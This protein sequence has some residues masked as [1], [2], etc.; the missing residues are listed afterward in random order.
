MS[1]VCH[2]RRAWQCSA[3]SSTWPR[4]LS[5]GCCAVTAARPSH[6]LWGTVFNRQHAALCLAEPAGPNQPGLQQLS[7]P[8]CVRRHHRRGRH[9][10]RRTVCAVRYTTARDPSWCL[11]S[12][13]ETH[14]C[15]TCCSTQPVH[16][17]SAG[18]HLGPAGGEEDGNQVLTCAFAVPWPCRS[19]QVQACHRPPPAGICTCCSDAQYT[20]APITNPN[21]HPAICLGAGSSP[22]QAGACLPRC[23]GQHCH[24]SQRAA[25]GAGAGLGRAGSACMCTLSAHAGAKG[26]SMQG[27]T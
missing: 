4:D 19:R 15:P 8:G 25:A 21:T 16:R 3:G 26:S 11:R 20:A 2:Q 6:T 1:G 9:G 14:Y 5:R 7:T 17:C 13:A 18:G 22:S 10:G 12:I 27:C 23:T 24:S